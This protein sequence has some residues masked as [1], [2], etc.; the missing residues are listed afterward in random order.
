MISVSLY[1]GHGRLELEMDGVVENLMWVRIFSGNHIQFTAC[2]YDWSDWYIEYHELCSPV[3][4]TG[5]G[6]FTL[7]DETD[8]CVIEAFLEDCKNAS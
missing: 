6:T 1:G 2:R 8:A 5:F 3:F 4:L 7:S